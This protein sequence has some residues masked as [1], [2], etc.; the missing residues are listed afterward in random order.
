[1]ARSTNTA[2]GRTR[3]TSQEKDLVTDDGTSLISVVNGEQ[4]HLQ[5]TLNWMT[6]TVGATIT[7]KIVEGDNSV[8]GTKPTAEAASAA[9][10]SLVVLDADTSDN[11]IVVVIPQDLI[12]TWAQAPTPGNPVWGFLGIEI[13]D[14]QTGSAQQIWKPVR[15]MVEVLYSPTEAV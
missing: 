5:F 6:T 1:M 15:G 7:A 10:V 11:V 13:A 8:A 14:A 3:I 4:L 12:A 2:S 9:I